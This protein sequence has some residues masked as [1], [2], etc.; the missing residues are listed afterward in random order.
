QPLIARRLHTWGRLFYELRVSSMVMF[1]VG[2]AFAACSWLPSPK[3]RATL[4]S[5]CATTCRLPR[6]S[7]LLIAVIRSAFTWFRISSRW[8][9]K[10]VFRSCCAAEM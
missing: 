8:P 4:S 2:A 1:S 3:L 6:L 9:S 5:K 10:S 7:A